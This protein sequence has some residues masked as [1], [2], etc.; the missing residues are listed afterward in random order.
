MRAFI[1][2]LGLVTPAGIGVEAARAA[3]WANAPLLASRAPFPIAEELLAPT[4]LV[5]LPTEEDDPDL[6]ATHRLAWLAAREAVPS[7]CV[8]DAI[9]VGG[10]TGGLAFT[11]DLWLRGVALALVAPGMALPKIEHLRCVHRN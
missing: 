10:T 5:S 4:G 9:I 1:T 3:L 7:G 11:E 2:G 6:P 8:P